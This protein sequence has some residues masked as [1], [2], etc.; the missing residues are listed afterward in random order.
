MKERNKPKWPKPKP[1][2]G[3]PKKIKGKPPEVK[4]RS[5]IFSQ[6]IFEGKRF[7]D[8]AKSALVRTEIFLA[9]Y[10]NAVAH[11][12]H[13]RCVKRFY[14]NDRYFWF[15]VDL[16]VSK[17]YAEQKLRQLYQQTLKGKPGLTR[18]QRAERYGPSVCYHIYD[19]QNL[20]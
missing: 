18:A 14:E 15:L 16:T 7:S 10:C 13:K 20:R 17:K 3:E 6:R 19:K 1:K 5:D 2:K 9:R 11:Q 4:P 12:L 8:E